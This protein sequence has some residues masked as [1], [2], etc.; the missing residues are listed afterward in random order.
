MGLP[1]TEL[2]TLNALQIDIN[3]FDEGTAEENDLPF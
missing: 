2:A 1:D 3:A